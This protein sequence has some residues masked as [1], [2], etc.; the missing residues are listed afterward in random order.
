ML[1]RCYSASG[2]HDQAIF[3]ARRAMTYNPASPRLAEVAAETFAAAG[4]WNQAQAAAV[5]WRRLMRENPVRADLFISRMHLRAGRASEAREPIVPHLRAAIAAPEHHICVLA[6]QARI[7]IHDGRVDEAAAL[8]WPATQFPHYRRLWCRLAMQLTD[9]PAD[10]AAWLERIMTVTPTSAIDERILLARC[11]HT[12][13]RQ[14]GQRSHCDRA[15]A[16]LHE[17]AGQVDD[18]AP[19]LFALASLL[20]EDDRFDEAT[21]LYQRILTSHPDHAA[22]H[23]NL[24]ALLLR[25][26]DNADQAAH[27]ALQAVTAKPGVAA[28]HGTLALALAQ[29][30]QYDRAIASLRNAMQLE[31]DALHWRVDLAAVCQQAGLP[32]QARAALEDLRKLV[33]GENRLPVELRERVR[34]LTN[35]IIDGRQETAA[36]GRHR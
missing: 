23:N 12:L 18:P 15:L 33:P 11:W 24:A 8:L 22:A 19:L 20:E 6:Q 3:T 29:Q 7:L 9:R 28:F 5:R 27:H 25:R 14:A 17:W 35:Q 30:Q 4:D 34:E 16:L 32:D 2:W 36:H 26:D 13:G 10:G 31:P 21:S 1:S